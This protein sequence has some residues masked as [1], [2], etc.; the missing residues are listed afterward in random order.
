MLWQR[1]VNLTQVNVINVALQQKSWDKDNESNHERKYLMLTSRV[2]EVQ[3]IK[4]SKWLRTFSFVLYFFQSV[5]AIDARTV[6]VPL[7]SLVLSLLLLFWSPSQSKVSGGAG[8]EWQ[9]SLSPQGES[10]RAGLSSP[11]PIETLAPQVHANE[12]S[13]INIPA[14]LPTAKHTYMC[15]SALLRTF[16]W[17]HLFPIPTPGAWNSTS[18]ILLRIII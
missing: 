3:W 8:G 13:K 1:L 15:I 16:H 7:R 11:S 4:K 9:A 6:S 14:I 12:D 5:V 10:G 2:M 18:I 17:M